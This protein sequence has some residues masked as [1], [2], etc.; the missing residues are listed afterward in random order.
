MKL[1][2]LLLGYVIIII[3]ETLQ[4]TQ[5]NNYIVMSLVDKIKY[6]LYVRHVSVSLKSN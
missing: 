2:F 1:F 4:Y 6:V 3:I 5:I